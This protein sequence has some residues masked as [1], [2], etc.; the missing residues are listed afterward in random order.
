LAAVSRFFKHQGLA[1]SG[2]LQH[3]QGMT[4][5]EIVQVAGSV[6]AL[7]RA[8]MVD[9]STVCCWR[10]RGIPVNRA[11]AIFEALGIPLHEIRPDVWGP[12]APPEDASHLRELA[13]IDA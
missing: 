7:A 13:D 4:F 2:E 6:G 10:R 1:T 9:H 3:A 8:V 11:R 12:S 5:D